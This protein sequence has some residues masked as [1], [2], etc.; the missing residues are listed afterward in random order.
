MREM[1]WTLTKKVRAGLSRRKLDSF[2]G[3]GEIKRRE[4]SW[5]LTKKV[6]LICGSR[7]DQ[8][9]GG[10]AGPSTEPSTQLIFCRDKHVYNFV[11]AKLKNMLVA[12]KDVFCDDKHLCRD[13]NGTLGRSRQRYIT[14]L[15]KKA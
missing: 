4:V 7:R 14:A 1:S 5:T 8:D 11:A 6:R 13:K 12:T 3:P 15:V 2:A 10:G 9:E